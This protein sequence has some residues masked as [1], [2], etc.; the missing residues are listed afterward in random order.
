MEPISYQK[1]HGLFSFH[2]YL[3]RNFNFCHYICTVPKNF[4]FGSFFRIVW[5]FL[6]IYMWKG[7]W[8]LIDCDCVFGKKLEVGVITMS[9][10]LVI[11][12]IFGCLKSVVSVPM[13]IGIDDVSNCC[14]ASTYLQT[15]VSLFNFTKI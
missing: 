6:D 12:T 11:L 9:I 15:K 8:D 7:L 3:G 2:E 14:Y 13:A 4:G 5:G 10:G 1:Q